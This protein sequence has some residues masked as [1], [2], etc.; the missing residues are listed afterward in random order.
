[1]G[2][3][4]DP[5]LT[6]TEYCSGCGHYYPSLVDETGWCPQCTALQN[7]DLKVCTT[8]GALYSKKAHHSKCGSCRKEEWYTKHADELERYLAMGH[9]LTEAIE[10][11]RS[12]CRPIC[13]NC[14]ESIQGG[15]EGNNFCNKKVGCRKA[16]RSFRT[17][18]ASGLSHDV[19]LAIA[20][21]RVTVLS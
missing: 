13:K 9:T 18:R 17:L 7:P 19:A 8:C 4:A 21:G 12:D 15:T 20:T 1:M 5:Q 14:G 2:M 6:D 3:A 10:C 16:A 11:V